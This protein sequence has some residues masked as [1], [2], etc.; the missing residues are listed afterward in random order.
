MLI[1]LGEG[2]LAGLRQV[3]NMLSSGSGVWIGRSGACRKDENDMARSLWFAA[4]RD[5]DTS[6][7]QVMQT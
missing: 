3:R 1:E 7:H 2:G 5:T 4:W 6:R